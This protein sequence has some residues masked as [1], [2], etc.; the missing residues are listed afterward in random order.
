MEKTDMTTG[1]REVTEPDQREADDT[2]AGS[3]G[4]GGRLRHARLMRGERMKDLADRAGCSESLISKIENEKIQPSI[5]VLHR[6]CGA[7]E[8]T[9][10]ELFAAPGEPDQV[11]TRRGQRPVVE[12]DPL[13]RGEGV[14]LER[15]IPYGR[16]HLLQSNIH[17][18]APGGSSEG[19]IVHHG[20]EVGYVIA[21]DVELTLGK[22][23]YRM[24]E[25][26]SFCF[27][28]DVPHGYR[29]CGETEARILFVN[30]PPTF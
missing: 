26:D 9:F 21:G 8:M 14:R 25:G 17:V 5:K 27:R 16:G 20:E 30:T 28:S 15:V 13:R 29:N 11:V 19:Q 24:S 3:L 4:I 22:R 10:G 12:F 2:V 1:L 7:L 18:I 23:N 6:I